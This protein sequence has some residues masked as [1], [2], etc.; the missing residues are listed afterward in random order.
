MEEQSY[1]IFRLHDLL[2]GITTSSVKEIFQLP[3]ITPIPEAPPDIIGILNLRGTILPIMHLERRLGQPVSECTIEDSV[4]VMEWNMIEVGIT[5]QEVLDVQ[6]I[7][8]DC[9]ETE[10]N[11]GRENHINTAFIAGIAKVGDQAIIL[12]NSEALIRHPDEVA[13]MI[14]ENEADS[15]TDSETLHPDKILSN[16]YDL[17]CPQAGIEEKN[18]FRQRSEEL[19]QPLEDLYAKATVPLAVFSLGTEY[20]ALDLELV[21]EFIDTSEITS[22]PCCPDYIVGNINLRGQIITVVDLSPILQLDSV[23]NNQNAQIMVI[24]VDDIKAGII[25]D[26]IFDVLYLDGEKL[27]S[28]PT[29]VASKAKNYVLGTAFY[30]DT[31]LTR[32]DLIKI[33]AEDRLVVK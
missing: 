23:R 33:L 16:F 2:C 28:T 18:L 32:I 17:Y 25:V 8:D 26:A 5:I 6:T 7:P 13:M 12:L 14:W 3:E 22:I 20:F 27:S 11:Y 21:K 10:P 30:E 24:E 1:L 15:E 31:M 9:I 19:R 4:I 29:A